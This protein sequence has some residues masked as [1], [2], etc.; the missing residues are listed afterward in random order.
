ML[1]SHINPLDLVEKKTSVYIYFF[2]VAF[3]FAQCTEKKDLEL[4]IDATQ[5]RSLQEHS[6][7]F[8][9]NI[10]KIGDNIYVAIGF[11]LA[12]SIMIVGDD[13][14][15]IVDCMESEK[16]ATAVKAKFDSISNLPI[17]ALVYTHFH[18]DHTFG[19]DIFAE[20]ESPAVI[21]HETTSDEL[22][23]LVNIRRPITQARSFRMF[24]N[25]LNDEE[26]INAGIGPLLNMD[27]ELH[28]GAIRP[29]VTF[30]VSMD[31][32][33]AGI[34]MQFHHAPGET[35]D[36]LFVW[37]EDKK[38]LLAGDNIYKTFPNLYTIRGTSY[39]DVNQWA[40]S[41]DKMRYLQPEIVIPSHT[42]PIEGADIVY[43][44]LTIYRDAIQFVHDQTVRNM[45]LGY[46]I[47]EIVEQV[48]LPN[49]LAQSPYLQ[50]FY[51]RVDWS[52][53]S[54]FTGY[55]GFFDGNPA[56]LIPSIGK[57]KAENMASLAGGKSELLNRAQHAFDDGN[58]QWSLELTDHLLLL[59]VDQ[60]QAKKIRLQCLIKLGQNHTNPN[61]RHYYLTCAKELQ[62]LKMK[63][64]KVTGEMARNLP[65]EA[66]FANLAVNLI[67]E[68]SERVDQLMTVKF[69]E[70]DEYWSVYVRNGVAEIQNFEL[71]NASISVHTTANDWKELITGVK[72]GLKSLASGAVSIEEGSVLD[73]NEFMGMFK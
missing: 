7:E 16:S 4:S 31:T 47:D 64:S 45:N 13:G 55:M 23:K 40:R 33:I 48:H 19:A 29:N 8:E 36:Q 66:I 62:G 65:I 28:L 10:L 44:T 25:F 58:Y 24:G 32:T 71:P 63:G 20:D 22:D 14:R 50:E 42:R 27:E 49:A 6:S 21:A 46:T 61:A 67:P 9:K 17:K 53:K 30:S 60:E 43:E 73:F 69:T 2:C 11:G 70:N 15:I 37:L 72:G 54:I 38:I 51:G 3:L 57:E 68:K 1:F 34:N 52:V 56:T 59:D 35:D 39:R 5:A 12:N 41:I 18:P 26:L